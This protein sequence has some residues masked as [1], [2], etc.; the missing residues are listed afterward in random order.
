MFYK[1][2]VEF[3]NSE[4]EN[5]FNDPRSIIITDE[6]AQKYFALFVFIVFF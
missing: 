6:M 1:F 2:S 3:L 4:R 5:L